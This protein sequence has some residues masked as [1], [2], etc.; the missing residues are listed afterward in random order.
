MTIRITGWQ[1]SWMLAGALVAGCDKGDD[2]APAPTAVPSSTGIFAPSSMPVATYGTVTAF[3]SVWVNGVRYDT[4]R[5]TIKVDDQIATERD[6]HVGDVVRVIGTQPVACCAAAAADSLDVKHALIGPVSS[7]D[8]PGASLVALGQTVVIDAGVIFDESI[9]QQSLAGVAVGDVVAVSGFPGRGGQI[10]ASRISKKPFGRL[11]V[12]GTATNVD[13]EKMRLT[14]NGLV[15]DFRDAVLHPYSP[16]NGIRVE[17][18]GSLSASGEF[19]AGDIGLDDPRV[20][21]NAG[22]RV[23]LEGVIEAHD[24]KSAHPT[25]MLH[26]IRVATSP[27][28]RYAGPTPSSWLDTKAQVQGVLQPDQSV[29]AS[30][31]RFIRSSPVQIRARV[32]S[33]NPAAGSFVALGITVQTQPFTR[34]TD[35]SATR[36]QPFG[37][38]ALAPG[39]YVHVAAVAETVSGSR[40]VVAS[41]VERLDPQDETQLQGYAGTT[42]VPEGNLYILGVTVST[43]STTRYPTPHGGT[44]SAGTFFF[45]LQPNALVDVRGIEVADR[46]I[47]ATEVRDADWF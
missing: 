46:E 8:A 10:F 20:R 31:V 7:V 33:V 13:L 19:L 5:A 9:P 35:E 26:G 15:V 41:L 43:T 44:L 40:L 22:V 30:Y 16:V 14:I 12:T 2:R 17:L 34:I 1:A 25:F 24:A 38:S 32:D 29:V 6:L 47:V 3:G 28:T 21:V 39:D 18:Q 27:G 11:K 45:D 42:G 36:A 37:L 4:S 23:E